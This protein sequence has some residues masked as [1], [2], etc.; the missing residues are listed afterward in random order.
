MMGVEF[1]GVGQYRIL[2]GKGGFEKIKGIDFQKESF[3]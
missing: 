1:A 3:F 2:P